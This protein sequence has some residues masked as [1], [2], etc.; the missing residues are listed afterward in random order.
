MTRSSDQEPINTDGQRM[1]IDPEQARQRLTPDS[2]SRISRLVC[3]LFGHSW[4]AHWFT[5]LESDQE[6]PAANCRRCGEI[7]LFHDPEA[8]EYQR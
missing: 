8:G 7:R 2:Q 6:Q 1:E 3:R 4:N 5:P